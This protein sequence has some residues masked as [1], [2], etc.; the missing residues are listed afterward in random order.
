MATMD[1]LH[2]INMSTT[3]S[4]PTMYN[5]FEWNL[6]TRLVK[7]REAE[8]RAPCSKEYQYSRK[9]Y[10]W[11]PSSWYR[12]ATKPYSAYE[13]I[14]TSFSPTFGNLSLIKFQDP[15]FYGA[16]GAEQFYRA[17]LRPTRPNANSGDTDVTKR[18]SYTF[19]AF[20]TDSESRRLLS[21]SQLEIRNGLA[22]NMEWELRLINLKRHYEAEARSEYRPYSPL[23]PTD[24]SMSESDSDSDVIE[25][26]GPRREIV[27]IDLSNE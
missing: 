18:F 15:H 6:R 14:C 20:L 4:Y 10:C 7:A 13:L 8:I 2:L 23:S 24:E 16:V 3:K 26:E 21:W 25:V 5:D 9:L 22:S 27:V 17:C 11:V 19:C 1:R 12:G